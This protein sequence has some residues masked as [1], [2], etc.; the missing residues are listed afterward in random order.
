MKLKQD[1]NRSKIKEILGGAEVIMTVFLP[2][3]YERNCFLKA[4]SET[5]NT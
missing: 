4:A 3:A 2:G 1:K 5:T